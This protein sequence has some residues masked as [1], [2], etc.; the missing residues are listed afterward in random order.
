MSA[1]KKKNSSDCKGRSL[2]LYKLGCALVQWREMSQILAVT[3]LK[4]DD[5][6]RRKAVDKPQDNSCRRYKPTHH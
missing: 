3:A 4:S 6:P 1:L 2:G 5:L